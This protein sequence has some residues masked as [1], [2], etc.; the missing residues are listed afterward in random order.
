MSYNVK[1]KKGFFW[2]KLKNVIGDGYVENR[3]IRF[4]MLEDLTRVEI[5]AKQTLFVFSKEREEE[6]RK[7]LQE[8]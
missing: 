8:K 2:K 1:Y 7:N 4:F 5:P 6:A 3:D